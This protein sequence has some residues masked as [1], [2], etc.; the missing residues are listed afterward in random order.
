MDLVHTLVDVECVRPRWCCCA[1]A[2]HCLPAKKGSGTRCLAA[3]LLSPRVMGASRACLVHKYL[4][5]QPEK[6]WRRRDPASIVMGVQIWRVH[7]EA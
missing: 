3:L 4:A 2:A 1:E 6:A 5:W 7:E